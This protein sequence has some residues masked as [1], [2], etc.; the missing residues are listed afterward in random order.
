MKRAFGGSAGSLVLGALSAKPASREELAD[1]R[2]MLDE[3]AKQ[4]GRQ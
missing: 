3:F 1:I 4:K 2:K